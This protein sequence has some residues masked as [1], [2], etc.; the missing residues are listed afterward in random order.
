MFILRKINSPIVLT[1]IQWT[2]YNKKTVTDFVGE[3]L[4][5]SNKVMTVSTEEGIRSVNPKDWIG[6][7]GQRIYTYKA[8]D[9]DNTF[10]LVDKKKSL[11]LK[12]KLF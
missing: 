7:A 12:K 3:T 9:F 5:V 2:G 11:F 4:E 1:A 10:R 6:K 8:E